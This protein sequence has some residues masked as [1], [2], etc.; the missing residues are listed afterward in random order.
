MSDPRYPTAI[1]HCPD[2]GVE[3]NYVASC[4]AEMPFSY[5]GT[6][7]PHQKGSRECL[8]RQVRN[9]KM[10]FERLSEEIVGKKYLVRLKFTNRAAVIVDN[11]LEA[12][13]ERARL[14]EPDGSW[15]HADI[16][17]ITR[18][19]ASRTARVL[20][21]EKLNPQPAT[22]HYQLYW[23]MRH[24]PVVKTATFG[25]L[26][27]LA[28]VYNGLI[29]QRI[30]M[31]TLDLRVWDQTAELYKSIPLPA[32][33]KEVIKRATY[34]EAEHL[35]CPVCGNVDLIE[36]NVSGRCELCYTHGGSTSEME[37][38]EA[39]SNATRIPTTGSQVCAS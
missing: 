3:C 2:C 28:I 37:P 11:S 33:W 36:E 27:D 4:L 10:R 31:A 39:K 9:L 16:E 23:K 32:N 5:P 26:E 38:F 30:Q 35:K 34:G 22:C 12:A 17:V 13:I 8:E 19:R 29:T 7:H 20:A 14:Y 15:E 1:I 24:S 18:I 21:M 6:Y 25:T